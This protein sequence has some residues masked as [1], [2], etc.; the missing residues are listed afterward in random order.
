MRV[1]MLGI[2][3]VYKMLCDI[4]SIYTLVLIFS[5]MDCIYLFT[6]HNEC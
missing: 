1:S 2:H 3:S 5:F 6:N 4:I